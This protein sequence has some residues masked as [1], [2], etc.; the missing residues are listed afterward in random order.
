[1]KE[2]IVWII[3]KY[4][5]EKLCYVFIVFGVN[6][7]IEFDFDSSIRILNNLIEFV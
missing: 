4:G 7:K 5:I 2:I 3:G 1:M 6:V